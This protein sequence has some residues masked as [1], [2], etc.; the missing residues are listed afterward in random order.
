MDSGNELHFKRKPFLSLQANFDYFPKNF[1]IFL[2]RKF[3]KS[4]NI[5]PPWFSLLLT[6]AFS[7]WQ[8]KDLNLIKE[9]KD[10]E[11]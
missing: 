1:T 4:W 6:F 9:K 3:I 5:F 8:N 2:E 7:K 11:C 10:R